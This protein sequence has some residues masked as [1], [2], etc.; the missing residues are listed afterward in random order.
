MERVLDTMTGTTEEVD[1]SLPSLIEVAS[2]A[3]VNEARSLVGEYNAEIVQRN[4]RMKANFGDQRECFEDI[5][6]T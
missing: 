2:V 5:L 3:E 4:E 6:A 1:N